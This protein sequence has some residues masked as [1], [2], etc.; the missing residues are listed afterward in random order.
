MSEP[1]FDDLL[2]ASS[3]LRRGRLQYLPVAPGRLEFAVEVRQA[4]LRERPD[5]VAV[6]L[7]ATLEAPYLRA[8]E[9][10]PQITVLLYPDD[11]EEDR[12]VYVPVEPADPF[13]ETVRA[14]QN[15]P[16]RMELCRVSEGA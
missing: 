7:P 16:L 2:K 14:Q 6:E 13:T 9:R 8:I 12:G 1:Q 3:S 4:I 5:V 15:W 11:K 10:L